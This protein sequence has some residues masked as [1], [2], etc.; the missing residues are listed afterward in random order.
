MTLEN[1]EYTI[2]SLI[3]YLNENFKKKS[4]EKFNISDISQYFIR[5][6]LPYRY[7]GQLITTKKENGVKIITLHENKTK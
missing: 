4:G 2:Q 3:K 7:G 1:N 5:G 6:Y